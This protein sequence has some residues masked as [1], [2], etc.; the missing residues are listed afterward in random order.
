MRAIRTLLIVVVVL[1]GLFV[2]ADR[3]AVYFAENKAADKIRSSQNLS[4][5]PDVSIKGFPFLTQLADS[6]LD[7]VDVSL[8]DG[9]TAN[10]G[11]GHAIRV[12]S[13]DA[14][15][16]GV[17]INSSF[18]SAVAERASGTA[19]LNYDD[20]GRALGPAV[21]VSYAGD[22][23]VKAGVMG[24]S[25]TSTLTVAGGNAIRMDAS[26]VPVLRG[27]LDVERRITGLPRGIQLEKVTATDKGVDISLG[28]TDV[29]LAGS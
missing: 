26:Q 25:T 20:L 2:A 9:V 1:G 12:S 22:G 18:S 21:S 29:R 13:F 4:G 14:Q 3:A 28:G 17:K 10:T 19:H 27:K 16:H 7:E 5:T 23:K 8:D 11:D 15:L 6:K 24:F